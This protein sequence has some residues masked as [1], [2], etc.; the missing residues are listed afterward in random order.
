MGIQGVTVFI[1]SSL[2]PYSPNGVLISRWTFQGASD[3]WDSIGRC[4]SG[5][6]IRSIIE[7]R[8]MN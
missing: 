5:V 3:T 8:S 1:A 4:N 6:Q 7:K 2:L